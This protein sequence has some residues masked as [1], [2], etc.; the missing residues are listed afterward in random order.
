MKN[1][2]AVNESNM[3]LKIDL[4]CPAL[5]FWDVETDFSTGKTAA[6]LLDYNHKPGFRLL[7]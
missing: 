6:S 3:I 4:T 1:S 5:S 7:L 2:I